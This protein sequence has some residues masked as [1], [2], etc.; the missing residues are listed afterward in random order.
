[1]YRWEGGRRRTPPVVDLGNA[2]SGTLG[3]LP[4]EAI[5]QAASEDRVLV[6]VEGDEVKGY[7]L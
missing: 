3:F 4:Y 2:N 1:M 5:R 7:A 6:Y